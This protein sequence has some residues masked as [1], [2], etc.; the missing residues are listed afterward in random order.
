MHITFI[1]VGPG[2]AFVAYPELVSYLPPRQ[3][4][5]VLFFFMLV[6]LGID[7]VVSGYEALRNNT[8]SLNIQY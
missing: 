3:L 7:N 8:E 6:L 2:L 5:S 4:W 1:C